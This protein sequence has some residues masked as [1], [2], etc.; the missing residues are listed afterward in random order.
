MKNIYTIITIKYFIEQNGGII[1][2][3]FQQITMDYFKENPFKIIG[4]DWMAISAEKDNKVNA[5]TASWGGLGVMWG[6]NVAFIVVRDSRYT[7]EFIDAA[8][9][10]SLNFF[11]PEFKE[12]KEALSYLG[13]YSGKNDPTKI[14]NAGFKVNFY[15]DENKKETPIIDEARMVLICKKMFAQKLTKDSFLT[16]E[17]EKWY[18]DGDYHTLYIAEI[19]QMLGR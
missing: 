4:K 19:Q 7:K 1:M 18:K 10:F 16:P 13:T 14:K 6:K 12:Y 9:T 15:V 3:N 17:I 2:H 8:D 11:N 5:M